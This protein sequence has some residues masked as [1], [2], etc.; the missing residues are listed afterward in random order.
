VHATVVFITRRV[1]DENHREFFFKRGFDRLKAPPTSLAQPSCRV[2][3][4]YYL[5]R[6][7]ISCSKS[8]NELTNPREAQIMPELV[9]T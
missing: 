2:T 6:A 4:N 5:S 3:P 7:S 9:I 1:R 8:R